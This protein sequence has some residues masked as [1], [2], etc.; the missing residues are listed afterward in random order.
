MELSSSPSA[1]GT[2]AFESTAGLLDFHRLFYMVLRRWW[3]PALFTV[4]TV[5]AGASYLHTRP[6]MYSALAVVQVEQAPQRIVNF[7][8]STKDD[9]YSSAD[10]LKT[11]EQVLGSGSL[12]LRVVK[13]NGLEHNASFAPPRPNGAPYSDAELIER[14]QRKVAVVIRRGTRLIDITVQDTNPILATKLASSVVTEYRNLELEQ[15]LEL[16]RAANEF[17]IV[18]E[19]K[20]RSNL[21]ASEKALADYRAQN[22]AVSLQDKQNIVVDKLRELNNQVTEAKSRRLALESDIAKVNAG[23]VTPAQ[24][25]Q[26]TSINSVPA[27]VD[28]RRQINE[29]EAE[30][31]AIKERYMYK[32]I[33]YIEAEST[34]QKLRT[35]LQTEF[36]GAAASLNRTYQSSL[37]T[38]HKLEATLQEQEQKAFELDKTAIPYNDLLR[39][40]ESN[41]TLYE[42]VLARMKQTDMIKGVSASDLRVV[43]EPTQPYR[44]DSQGRLKVLAVALAAGLFL[45]LAA[46]LAL[47]TFKHTLQTVDQAERVLGLPL[48]AAVPELPRRARRASVTLVGA[49][50]PAQREAFR[51]LRATFGLPKEPEIRSFLLTSAIPGEGKSFCSLNFAS[52]LAQGGFHT[53]LL[54]ADLRRSSDYAKALDC[55]EEAGLSESLAET[56]PFAQAC[57]PTKVQNLFYCPAGRRSGDPSDL[58]ASKRVGEIIKEALQVFD[59][60]V[61]DTPPVNAVSDCMTLAAHVEAVCLVVRARSTPVNAVL[62]AGRILTLGGATP[63]GFILNRMP[64]RLGYKSSHYYYGRE[65][66]EAERRQTR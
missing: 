41:R 29:K 27:V 54:N 6:V 39:Q 44:P 17:L 20:L 35:A 5:A 16:N 32:H 31:A 26:L 47:E 61:I 58:L 4:L 22:Q 45:G 65:Y 53:L 9:E 23:N 24:L 51:T 42:N 25:L 1:G 60:V 46:I 7:P 12:L 36:A 52:T 56:L 11:F 59:R 21:E 15:K 28:L 62:R 18:E 48:L 64:A 37:E 10:A 2:A 38:E 34:L 14:M 8:D 33:K 40:T 49:E 13:A 66:H 50:E 57:H 19:R 55:R 3:L 30:F 43:Q 63:I